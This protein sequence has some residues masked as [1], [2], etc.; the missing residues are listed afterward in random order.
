MKPQ[1]HDESQAAAADGSFQV[2][3]SPG[4]AELSPATTAD[5]AVPYGPASHVNRVAATNGGSGRSREAAAPA[6]GYSGQ[7]T[8]GTSYASLQTAG[9]GKGHE[10]YGRKGPAIQ[11]SAVQGE[12]YGRKGQAAQYDEAAQGARAV[13]AVQA[14]AARRSSGAVS[15][16][17]L[18]Q[19]WSQ[20]AR[21]HSGR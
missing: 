13:K 12:L 15:W 11:Y 21:A 18:S 19:Q 4:P 2:H 7:G 1:P 3:A 16:A 20:R 6:P 8:A 9:L 17:A 5:G 10:L 14:A